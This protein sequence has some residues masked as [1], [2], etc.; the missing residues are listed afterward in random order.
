MKH[1]LKKGGKMALLGENYFPP[2]SKS[3]MSFRRGKALEKIGSAVLQYRPSVVYVC[4]TK[5]VNI[6]LIPLLMMNNIKLRIVMP[7]KHFFITLTDEEKIILDAACDYA[8]KIIILDQGKADPLKFAEDW[9]L[10]SERA[11]ESSDWVLVAHNESFNNLMVK[12]DGNPKPVL[13]V[14][15]G[16]EEQYL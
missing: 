15:F 5:G 10:A 2:V 16:V 7:R 4:P 12:F 3:H 6:N 13:A 8:D 9:Y 11:V 14:D 1:N